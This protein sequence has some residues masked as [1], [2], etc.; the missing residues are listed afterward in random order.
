MDSV[1]DQQ[2]AVSPVIGVILMVAITVILAAVIGTFVLG[3]GDQVEDEARAGVN[4]DVDDSKEEVRVT[5]TTMGN[6]DYLILRG[7]IDNSEVIG[8]GGDKNVPVL[9]N[10]G[11]S[12][13]LRL[14][15]KTIAES[16]TI[17]VVAMIGDIEASSTVP[18]PV[19]NSTPQFYPH[20]F[21]GAKKNEIN[22]ETETTIRTVD[23]DFTT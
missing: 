10:T 4:V 6:A 23:Y 15:N 13:T 19:F 1:G 14:V 11:E 5:V 7:D 3:L 9:E 20:D 21:N 8:N 2:E 17:S 22:S 16:G 12:A 18:R